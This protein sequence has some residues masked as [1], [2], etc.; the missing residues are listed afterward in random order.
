MILHAFNGDIFAVFYGLGLEDL[1]KGTLT[2]LGDQAVFCNS[3]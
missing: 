1:G 3:Q 2:L